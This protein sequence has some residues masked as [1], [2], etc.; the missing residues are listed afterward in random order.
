MTHVRP[1]MTHLFQQLGLDATQEGIEKFI[2][3]HQLHKD[4]TLLD[5]PYWSEAQRQFLTEKIA[6]DGSWA[7]VVDQLNESLHENSTSEG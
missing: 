1:R 5:A 6:S 3:E 2:H 7:I 4:L